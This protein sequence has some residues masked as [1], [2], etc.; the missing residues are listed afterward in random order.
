MMKRWYVLIVAGLLVF[1]SASAGQKED[2]EV[3]LKSKIDAVLEILPKKEIAQEE[4]NSKI[5]AIVVGVFDF[6]LMAKLTLG[7]TGWQQMNNAQQQEFIDLFVARLKASY[8][9]KS[10]LY[11]DEKVDYKPAVAAGDKIH[12]PI[13]VIG[14]EKTVEVVYK[15]YAS[16]NAWKIYDVEINGVSLI[17]SYRSQFSEILRNGTVAD[18]LQEL[19]KKAID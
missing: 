1:S 4:K 18:L 16:G 13:D 11:S 6:P 15:F 2:V 12:V 9:D 14:K 10:S 5:M 7:K 19:R 17:Q 8:L 3:L